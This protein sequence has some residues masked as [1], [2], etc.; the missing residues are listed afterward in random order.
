ML[1]KET[2]ATTTWELL[3]HLQTE[4]MLSGFRLVG[5]TALALQIG[6][7]VSVDLDLFSFEAFDEA[8]LLSFLTSQ[9][10][11]RAEMIDRCTLKGE[12]NGVQID[13][14][15]HEYQW[16]SEPVCDDG[17]VLAG[18]EDI[19]AMKLNAIIGNGTRLKDF[20]DMAYLSSRMT[21]SQM[22]EAYEAK[23]ST[24][25]IIALKALTY[26]ED[27]NQREPIKML[28]SERFSWKKIEKRL[29]AMVRNTETVF[30]PL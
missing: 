27:V 30:E 7:R 29:L 25:P 8:R 23:Y 4:Q 2:L 17:V 3:K 21:L 6:H 20:I 22:L 1:H 19:A 18:V 10:G 12:I 15:A 11:M 24:S 14:I 5:G 9:Y 26:W 16:I 28:S 13:C